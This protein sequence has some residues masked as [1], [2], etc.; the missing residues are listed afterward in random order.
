MITVYLDK[1]SVTDKR[2]TA[3]ALGNFDGIHL[4]HAELI[5]QTVEYAR[6][7]GLCSGVWSFD[8]YSAKKR[9]KNIITPEQ[10]SRVISSLGAEYLFLN[11]FGTVCEY[12]CEDFVKRVLIDK[13]GAVTV[14]CGYNFRFGKNASGDA[15]MLKT[16]MEKYGREA[17]IL[18]E[19]KYCD[20]TVSS[21]LIRGMIES[22]DMEKCRVFLGRPFFIDFKVVHGKQLGRT[23]GSPTIN[24]NFPTDHVIPMYGVYACMAE[25]DGVRYRACANVG[26][27]PSVENTDAVNCETHIIGYDGDLYG[28]F[29]KVEFFKFLRGEMKFSSVEELKEAISKDVEKTK[30]YFDDLNIDNV[31]M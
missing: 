20:S 11:D 8:G 6:K 12:T 30:R 28:R 15:E 29:V 16:L 3:L 2:D 22:G 25:V 26:V 14:F 27:R 24:Q 23:I 5:A 31:G 13:C 17:V 4:G 7:N 9:D 21:S 10:R 19:V 18:P 1:E